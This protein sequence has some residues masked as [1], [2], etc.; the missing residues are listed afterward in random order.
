MTQILIETSA[1]AKKNSLAWVK[2]EA[3]RC[4]NCYD[5]PCQKACPASIPI[6]SLIGSIRS[7]NFLRAAR[8][9]R[10]ANPMAATCGAVCPEEVFCQTGCTRGRIDSP[11]RIRELHQRATILEERHT[12]VI[13]KGSA[14]VAIIGSGPAGLACAAALARNGVRAVVFDRSGHAGGVPA[15]S[16]ARFRLPDR[17]I[18]KDIKYI[19]SLKVEST[20]GAAVD[21]PE[22]LLDDHDAVFIAAGLSVGKALGIPGEDL[23]GVM[24]ALPFLESARAGRMGSLAG[25]RVIVIGGGNVSLDVASVAAD[26]C[27]EE[28]HLLYRRGPREMKVWYSELTEA[29]SRGVIINYQVSPVGF[30]ASSG[31]LS[32]VKC[33]RMRLSE[34]RDVDRR[35]RPVLMPGTEFDISVDLAVIAVGLLSNY[36]RAIRV[37]ADLTTSRDGIFAGGDW[38]RGEGTIVEAVRDGKLAAETIMAYL[39]NKRK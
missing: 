25:K 26:L 14:R 3:G 33:C 7:G 18:R 34:H 22:S 31:K 35:R 24:G 9:I 5:P 19:K 6:P 23:P 21:N 28:V 13:H 30:I 15:H 10:D 12:D 17:V 27:A 38:A 36:A 29:L 1:K 20:L 39:R 4:L 37:N 2:S 11:I 8:L 16:I 32:T